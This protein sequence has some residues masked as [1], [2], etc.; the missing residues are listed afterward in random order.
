M[1]IRDRPI[2][3]RRPR[4]NAYSERVIGSIRRECLDHLIIFG[5]AHLRRV[6][7]AYSDSYNRV[8][9]HRSLAKD[10]PHDRLAPW[11]GEMIRVRHLGRLH[12]SLAR[13]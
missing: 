10:T 4:Q 9:T 7:A 1:G 12:D 8:R 6:L 2:A 11:I 3:S 13:I 5:E